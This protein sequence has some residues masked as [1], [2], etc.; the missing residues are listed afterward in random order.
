VDTHQ[1]DQLTLELIGTAGELANATD[2]LGGDPHPRGSFERA[3]PPRDALECASAVQ[4][5]RRDARLELGTEID[6]VPPKAVDDPGALGHEVV[7]VVAQQ[8]DLER[9]AIE[10]GGWKA[11][12]P[13]AQNGA[14]DSPRIDLIRLARLALAAPR[15]THQPRRNAHDA[16]AGT[17]ECLLQSAR[18]AATVLDR[19]NRLVRER[20]RPTQRSPVS[21]L[22]GPDL[23]F[24]NE[25]AGSGVDSR[26]RV[27]ALVGIRADHDH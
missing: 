1:R 3:Q 12:D 5:T 18:D 6:E 15:R 22:V 26:E 16:F 14:R 2:E 20:A 11:L 7:A 9:L 10:N 4:V 13:F 24:A 19:P 21:V 25:H 23:K 8:A 17:E 27:R